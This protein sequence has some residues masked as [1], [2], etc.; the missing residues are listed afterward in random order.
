MLRS[1]PCVAAFLAALLLAFAA[2]RRA[3]A[4]SPT[5]K[6]SQEVQ[7]GGT[8]V[9]GTTTDIA[10]VNDIISGADRFS[11]DVISQMFLRLLDERPD[12]AKHPPTLAPELASSYSWSPDH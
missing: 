3:S 9:I 10:G 11:E 2:C 7:T 1:R 4:P 5:A 8:L 6:G 12:Y